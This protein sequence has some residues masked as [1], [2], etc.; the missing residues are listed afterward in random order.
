MFVTLMLPMTL[1]SPLMMTRKEFLAHQGV[2][3]VK[4]GQ[5]V[6]ARSVKSHLPSFRLYPLA[7]TMMLTSIENDHDALF[8][9]SDL[10]GNQNKTSYLNFYRTRVR[11]LGMLVSD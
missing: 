6:S 3:G 9:F 2:E 8:I 11:S 7:K 10:L 4:M 5:I 1:A